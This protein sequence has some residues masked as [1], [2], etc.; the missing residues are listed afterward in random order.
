MTDEI[1]KQSFSARNAALENYKRST[2]VNIGPP[3]PQSVGEQLLR[4]SDRGSQ[5][6]K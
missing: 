3:A 2:L 4:A 5:G 1:K 6:F